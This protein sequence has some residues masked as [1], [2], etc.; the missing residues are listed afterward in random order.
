M[1]AIS[2]SVAPQN[3]GCLLGLLISVSH[4][5]V[6]TSMYHSLGYATILWIQAIMTFERAAVE[7]AVV[8]LRHCGNLCEARRRKTGFLKSLV[9]PTPLARCTVNVS[10]TFGVPTRPLPCC[11]AFKPSYYYADYLQSEAK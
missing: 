1:E 9:C 6:Q 5:A 4:A 7:E 8:A 11:T 2:N 3:Y 10:Q